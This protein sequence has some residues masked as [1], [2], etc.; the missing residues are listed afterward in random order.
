MFRNPFSKIDPDTKVDFEISP[1]ANPISQQPV[2]N[3]KD[4][5]SGSENIDKNRDLGRLSFLEMSRIDIKPPKERGWENVP[6][7]PCVIATTH[8]SDIDVQEVAM[9]VAKK[10]KIGIASQLTNLT[11]F[12]PFV[13]LI[14]EKNF[15][16]ITNKFT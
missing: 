3:E 12:K 2:M 13:K 7:I 8:L 16:P 4:R 6:K 14:G 11:V 5:N 9:I 15:F 10:R 1:E